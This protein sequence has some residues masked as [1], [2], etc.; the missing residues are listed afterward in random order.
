MLMMMLMV[1]MNVVD[2]DGDDDDDG[3]DGEPIRSAVHAHLKNYSIIMSCEISIYLSIYS[4]PNL[5]Q[6]V[7]T[8]CTY[9]ARLCSMY[10]VLLYCNNA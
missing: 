9:Y 10:R 5:L 6:V 3:D 1:L 2:G 4:L 7:I 8:L